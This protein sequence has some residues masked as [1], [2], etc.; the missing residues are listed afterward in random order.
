MGAQALIGRRMGRNE[1]QKSRTHLCQ[2]LLIASCIASTC[3]MRHDEDC[4]ATPAGSKEQT[5][6]SETVSLR[7]Y[8]NQKPNPKTNQT[9]R[10]TNLRVAVGQQDLGHALDVCLRN[11]GSEVRP[12]QDGLELV[13]DI[14]ADLHRQAAVQHRI[15]RPLCEAI[16]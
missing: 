1:D 14:V 8:S 7:A 10:Q 4:N 5:T 2:T 15:L 13:G 16:A 3:T 12:A 6:C 9:L 11:S